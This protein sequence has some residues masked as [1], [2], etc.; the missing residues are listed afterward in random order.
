MYNR[1]RHRYHKALSCKPIK[2]KNNKRGTATT[3]ATT[4]AY[5]T[6]KRV[7]RGKFPLSYFNKH[8]WSKQYSD[9][10]SV[11]FF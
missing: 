9:A 10:V 2:K 4:V 7:F 3:T 6:L 11:S 8:G 1:H 5:V